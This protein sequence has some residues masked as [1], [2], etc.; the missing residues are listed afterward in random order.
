MAEAS[1]PRAAR[2]PQQRRDEIAE[3]VLSRGS[4]SVSEIVDTFDVSLATV[5][6]DLDELEH[7]GLLHKNHGGVTAQPSGIFE[8][9]VGYRLR[10]MLTEKRA[11]ARHALRYVSPGMSV[12]LDDSTTALQMVPL[13]A[14]RAPLRVATNY[15]EAMR[16]LRDVHGVGLMAF[17]G[18]YDP[19]HDSFYGDM[20]L[21]CI[22]SV[23]VDAAFVSTSAVSG[24]VAYHQQE[25]VVSFRRAMVEA[26]TH[27]YLLLDHSKLDK[28]ALYRLMPLSAFDLVIV[29][30]GISP[31]ALADLRQQQVPVE[32]ASTADE[33]EEPREPDEPAEPEAPDGCGRCGSGPLDGRFN[34]TFYGCA[35]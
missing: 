29:D 15:L 25:H 34:C 23:R 6:R 7:R 19:L 2:R 31:A 35:A 13:L 1:G 11:V 27:T 16:Q 14:A 22:T 21:T 9:N 28:V 4:V 3:F 18:E 17:G 33:S 5:H 8:S 24:P 30:D 10:S 26:A 32:V 20:C 12:I